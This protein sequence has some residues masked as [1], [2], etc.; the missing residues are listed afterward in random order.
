MSKYSE[1]GHT[2]RRGTRRYAD[3]DCS[4]AETT[5]AGCLRSRGESYHAEL[6]IR[7]NSLL[8]GTG[9]PHLHV[10]LRL[11]GR[12]GRA[13]RADIMAECEVSSS[14]T[15]SS[16][17]A[18]SVHILWGDRH[19]HM[20][21]AGPK[22]KPVAFEHESGVQVFASQTEAATGT[23]TPIGR[24]RDNIKTGKVVDGRSWRWA[25]DADLAAVSTPP[26]VD[27]YVRS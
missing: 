2:C 21:R 6:V 5:V 26:T 15:Q 17:S 12:A 19:L 22:G 18:P 9:G 13:G 14:F 10:F 25:T 4:R 24:I 16:I 8:V 27:T 1:L 3:A 20:S 11:G 23:A 7:C